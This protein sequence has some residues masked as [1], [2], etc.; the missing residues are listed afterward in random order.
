MDPAAMS[1]KSV[2]FFHKTQMIS[3]FCYT[4]TKDQFKNKFY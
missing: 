1:G 4:I 2:L 3:D